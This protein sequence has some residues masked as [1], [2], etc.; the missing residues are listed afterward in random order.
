MK[1]DVKEWIRERRPGKLGV[2]K[3][4]REYPVDE[5]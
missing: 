3:L 1:V 5:G 4:R 2:Y